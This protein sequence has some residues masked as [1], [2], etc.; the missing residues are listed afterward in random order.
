MIINGDLKFET[1]MRNM[2]KKEA[3]KLVVL[4]RILINKLIS[5]QVAFIARV[6]SHDYFYCT[7]YELLLLARVTSYCLLHKL[8][9][10]VFYTS[11]ELLFAYE[12]RVNLYI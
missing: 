1:H 9:V 7:S 5:L 4:N 11:Y 2:C 3:Q 6:T 8:R 12:L 10:T